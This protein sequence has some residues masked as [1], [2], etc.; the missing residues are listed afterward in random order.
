MHLPQHLKYTHT[1]EWV[2]VSESEALIGLTKHAVD[3]LGDIVYLELPK[4][5][6]RVTQGL[7]VGIVESVK[8]AAEIYSPLSGIV[9]AVNEEVI[10]DPGLLNRDCYD[11]GW[12]YRIALSNPEECATL[13]SADAYRAILG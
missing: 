13:L 7:S 6:M 8:A 11:Q 1:H 9:I 10:K 5:V 2:L 12:L 4:L 3:L